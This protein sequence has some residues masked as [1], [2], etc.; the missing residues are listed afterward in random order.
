[1]NTSITD[2]I[3]PTANVVTTRITT[4]LQALAGIQANLTSQI[5][6]AKQKIQD[7]VLLDDFEMSR[8]LELDAKLYALL[9]ER[10]A[11][12]RASDTN[13]SFVTYHE[14]LE[15]T[16]RQMTARLSGHR[17]SSTS[18][19]SNEIHVRRHFALLERINNLRDT[20]TYNQDA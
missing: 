7:E 17:H 12:E 14:V 5:A 3:D 1:V 11:L 9:T 20:L 16:L 15:E 13:H 6:E 19:M 10:Y 4:R 18:Q 2:T 8:I